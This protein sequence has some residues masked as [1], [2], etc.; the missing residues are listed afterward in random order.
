MC[1]IVP[2]VG[3]GSTGVVWFELE[4]DVGLTMLITFSTVFHNVPLLFLLAGFSFTGS[5]GVK[6]RPSNKFGVSNPEFACADISF[7]VPSLD[8][9]VTRAVIEPDVAGLG[10]TC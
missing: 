7:L 1:V 10:D 5:S 4:L 8:F 9:G 2:I 6:F 3:I